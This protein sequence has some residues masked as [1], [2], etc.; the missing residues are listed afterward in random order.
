M[1]NTGGTWAGFFGLKGY[2]KRLGKTRGRRKLYFAD[3]Y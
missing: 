1:W 2:Q 3:D